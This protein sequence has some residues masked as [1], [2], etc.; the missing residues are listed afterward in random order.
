MKDPRDSLTSYKGNLVDFCSPSTMDESVLETDKKKW[1]S[2]HGW[3][4]LKDRLF[5]D[6][7][8]KQLDVFSS[9]VPSRLPAERGIRHKTDLEPGT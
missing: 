3:E 4:D 6:V 5:Y 2:A 9:K 7:L 1:F 8:W